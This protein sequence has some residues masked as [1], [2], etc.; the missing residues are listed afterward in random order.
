M[1]YTG[2]IFKDYFGS[3]LGLLVAFL[4]LLIWVIVPFLFSL[5][6]FEHKDL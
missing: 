6:I 5:K 3:T 1:G 4:L 2:A